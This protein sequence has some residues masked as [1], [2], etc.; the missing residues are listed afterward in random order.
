M[1]NALLASLVIL[2][3]ACGGYQFPGGSSTPA[4]GTVSG[5]VLAVPCAAIEPADGQC[6]RPVPNLE[7]D[8]VLRGESRTEKTF[9]DANGNYSA[10]A[11]KVKSY[12][13]IIS[14]PTNLTVG[15][16]TS[17]VANYVLDTGLRISGP[18]QPS[19]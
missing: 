17:T 10:Y 14:G 8:F 2:T 6:V 19:S 4:A 12:M 9:T 1:R 18:A 5:R 3:A 11:V 13:R 7:L 15:A 16:G